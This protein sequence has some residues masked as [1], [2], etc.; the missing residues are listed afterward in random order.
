MRRKR[1]TDYGDLNAAKGMIDTML[2]MLAAWFL[3][4]VLTFCLL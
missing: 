3:T 1:K 2:I 4:A